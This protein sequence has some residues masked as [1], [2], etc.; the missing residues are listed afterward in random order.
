MVDLTALGLGIDTV[1]R[2]WIQ[3]VSDTAVPVRVASEI[4]AATDVPCCPIEGG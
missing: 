2:I 1:T 3:E 4:A